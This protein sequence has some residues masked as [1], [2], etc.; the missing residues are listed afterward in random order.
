[1]R[2][3]RVK[4]E[5][6][7][8]TLRDGAQGEGISFS[9]EDKLAIVKALDNL[10]IDYVE[11]GNP[12]S[13]PKEMEFFEKV[14][15]LK[16]KNTKLVAFGSTR[17]KNTKAKEDPNVKAI[18]SANTPAV[19]IFG[20]CWMLHV[21]EI[22]NTDGETNREMI[23]D[24]VKFLKDNG[25]T[26]FFDAEHFFD[27]YKDNPKY[28]LS[29]LEAAA[30]AGAD[31][32]V[33]CDTNGG[34]FPDEVFKITK[35][36][37]E[38]FGHKVGIH[39][40]NDRGMAVANSDMAIKAGATHLQGTFLGFGER[41]GNA[42]L[43]TLIPNLQIGQNFDCIPKEKLKL[44]T[45]T[46][47]RIAEIANTSIKRNEPY[48][49]VS[50]FAH[51]AGMHA[52][53]VLKLSRSF[54]HISPEVVGNERK[55]LMS[56][57]TGRGAVLEKINK[58]NPN[59]TKDS[60]E[61]MTIIEELKEM[62]NIGYQFEGADSSFEMLI[63][64]NIGAYR[65]FFNLLNYKII[66]GQPS[67]EGCSATATVKVEV[68]GKTQ[69]M[70]SEGNGPIN[71][72]DKALRSALEVF[73]PTLKDMRLIDYKV[74]VMDGKSATASTVRVLITS[75]DG[76]RVWTTVGV[77]GDVVDASRLALTESIEYKLIQDTVEKAAGLI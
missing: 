75:T 54:E 34:C 56:E 32:L 37:V 61:T 13:N 58:I 40:H 22:L 10:S 12:F 64:R 11:A 21:T 19:A 70:A 15:D 4:V 69:L 63:R 55:I 6:L 39:T 33:L 43:S 50:A 73:Y 3:K 36:V 74:R 77:S 45:S 26:V 49:G 53:G 76:S 60:P 7:D 48:I 42:N 14:N 41:C 57:I 67:E 28:A 66:T 30:D 72:F 20:K 2:N 5:I 68:E 23:Y 9:I 51:K 65:N 31:S 47:R 27:G 71:A 24:T 46:A 18:L 17:R 25:K 59:I 16:L 62:E 44:I 52:D 35:K 29:A 38:K 8:S 1:M